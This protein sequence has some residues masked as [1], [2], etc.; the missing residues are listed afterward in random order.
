MVM[1]YKINAHKS[2]AFLCIYSGQLKTEIKD[3]IPCATAPE[4]MK[5]SV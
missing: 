1:E 4:K 2:I 3:T 5:Y